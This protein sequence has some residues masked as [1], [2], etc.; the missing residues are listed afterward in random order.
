MKLQLV[1]FQR[2]KKREGLFFKSTSL[3]TFYKNYIK[4]KKLHFYF[5]QFKLTTVET[6]TAEIFSLEESFKGIYRREK[7]KE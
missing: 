6:N 1:V 4:M 7:W 3:T 2:R 5:Y